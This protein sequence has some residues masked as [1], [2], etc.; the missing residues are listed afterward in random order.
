M[1][2]LNIFCRLYQPSSRRPVAFSPSADMGLTDIEMAHAYE[3]E[4][5]YFDDDRAYDM[6]YE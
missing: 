5:P 1:T 3:F 4:D 6:E 2:Q